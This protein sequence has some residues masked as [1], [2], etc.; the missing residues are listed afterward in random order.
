MAFTMH[1][2]KNTID[3]FPEMKLLVP[4]SYIHVSVSE[5]YIPMID[6]PIW[7]QKNWQLLTDVNVNIVR[8][9]IIILFWKYKGREVSFLGI[10]KSEPDIYIGLSPALNL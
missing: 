9:N 10:F 7:L 2:S 6:L 3:V 4:N 1:C 8:Q 5:F